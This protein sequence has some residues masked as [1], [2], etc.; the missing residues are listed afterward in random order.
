MNQTAKE[1]F[2]TLEYIQTHNNHWII[3]MFQTFV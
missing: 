3:A 2:I 1:E